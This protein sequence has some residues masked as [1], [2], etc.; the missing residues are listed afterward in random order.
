M[1]TELSARRPSFH[2]WDTNLQTP[3][4]KQVNS[5]R[6]CYTRISD[7]FPLAEAL[8][9]SPLWYTI[10]TSALFTIS[11]SGAVCRRVC[12]TWKG[13]MYPNYRT[14]YLALSLT[15]ALTT[16][17]YTFSCSACRQ[18]CQV[19]LVTV[20]ATGNEVTLLMNYCHCNFSNRPVP[21][22]ALLL[23]SS[24]Y[25]V[26]FLFPQLLIFWSVFPQ[27]TFLNCYTN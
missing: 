18:Y 3:V 8:K 6:H 15:P 7:R 21:G 19:R 5:L 17:H 10:V 11:C 20:H 24:Y 2:S 16:P 27:F 26:T 12:R 25:S 4:T 14:E 9:T 13:C 1:E 22:G 23:S